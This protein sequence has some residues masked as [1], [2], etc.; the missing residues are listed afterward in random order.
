[1]NTIND[2]SDPSIVNWF[3]AQAD[4]EY[5]SFTQRLLPGTSPILG[6]RLPKI[7]S[8]A[9]KIAKEDPLNYLLTAK[10]DSFEKI[11]LQGMVIGYLPMDFS[12]V[13]PYIRDF[14]RKIDN[15]SV[16][17]SF[18]CGLK[19][20]KKYPKEMWDLINEFLVREEEFSIRFGIIMMLTY[21]IDCTHIE[22]VFLRLS[23]ITNRTYYVKMGIAWTVSICYKQFP[24]KT[25]DFLTDGSLSGELI[26]MSLKKIGELAHMTKEKKLEISNLILASGQP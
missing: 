2:F 6:V 26:Q 13:S 17:D 23:S 7:R 15:W 14:V 9:K 11:M 16:C 18:C 24:E 8:L 22:E 1:M 10:D 12:N 25:L 3:L 21:Y 19:I 4:P 20:A 5:Q